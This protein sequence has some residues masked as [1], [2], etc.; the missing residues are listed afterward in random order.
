MRHLSLK[1]DDALAE[2]IGNE[3]ETSGRKLSDVLRS[4][5]RA[6]LRQSSTETSERML[7]S[8]SSMKTK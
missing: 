3:V 7:S 2:R 5:L 4:A 6:G 1:V 8:R